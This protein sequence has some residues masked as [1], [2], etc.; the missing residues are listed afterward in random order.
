MRPVLLPSITLVSFPSSS[1][2]C[3][4]AFRKDKIQCAP[5]AR[6]SYTPVMVHTSKTVRVLH[7]VPSQLPAAVDGL[8]TRT[9]SLLPRTG[10]AKQSMSPEMGFR[11]F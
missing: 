7:P 3:F 2:P 9:N 6:K 11:H 5:I 4:T 8:G 10:V 1:L